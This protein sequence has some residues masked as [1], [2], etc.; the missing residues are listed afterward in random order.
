MENSYCVYRHIRP[1]KD[2]VFYIGKAV[3]GSKRPYNSGCSRRSDF[4]KKI[5]DKNNGKYGVEIIMDNL[6]EEEAFLKEIEFIELYGRKDLGTGTLC[7][8]T[9]GGEGPSGRKHSEESK[10]KMSESHKGKVLSEVTKS[11]LS[12]A[13]KGRVLTKEWK[14]KISNSQKGKKLTDEHEIVTGTFSV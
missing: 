5:V 8:M 11:K 6:T 7:N 9:Y 12:E 4:W 10:L 2:E 13:A 14:D 3:S 1:D